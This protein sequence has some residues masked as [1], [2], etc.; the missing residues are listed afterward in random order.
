MASL[1]S[2]YLLVFNCP[3]IWEDNVN[4]QD[5]MVVNTTVI[6]FNCSKIK[7]CSKISSDD[8]MFVRITYLH[9]NLSHPVLPFILC[10]VGL[11]WLCIGG[12]VLQARYFAY[13]FLF[14]AKLH[15]PTQAHWF[16]MCIRSKL[17][18]FSN[19]FFSNPHS[20]Q[21]SLTHFKLRNKGCFFVKPTPT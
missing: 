21:S 2:F 7:C 19:P 12:S 3:P 14:L 5:I 1:Y 4:C 6:L 13:Y 16:H 18:T 10:L 20:L 17:N 11:R 8:P 9:V 15:L